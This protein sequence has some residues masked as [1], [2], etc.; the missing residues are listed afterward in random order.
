MLV[1][2]RLCADDTTLCGH[3]DLEHGELL[4]RQRDVV[5]VAV[6]LAAEGVQTQAGD[7]PHGWP[8][9]G[10]PAVECPEPEDEF[11]EL[12]WL[13][14]VVVGAELETGRLVVEP[15][16]GSEHEDRHAGAGRDDAFGYLVAGRA[17][18]VAVED[19]DVVGVDAH[20]VQSSLAVAG[21]VGGDRFQPQAVANGL[22]HE[23]LVLDDQYA[24]F[25]D[26]REPPHIVGISKTANALRR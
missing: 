8:V 22:C 5:P 17:G 6:N 2:Q 10:T 23:R 26:A 3:E 15:V 21:D 11:L 13:G 18:D 9:V 12:E 24:H 25:S 7:L 1:Q 19:G 16:G 4:A 14:Q 20:H